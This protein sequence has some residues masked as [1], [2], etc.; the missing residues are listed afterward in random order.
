MNYCSPKILSPTFNKPHKSAELPAMI[1]LI[2][3][4][5]TNAS[6]DTL[7]YQ[8]SATINKYVVVVENPFR[9]KSFMSHSNNLFFLHS[10]THKHNSFMFFNK[11]PVSPPLGAIKAICMY[12]HIMFVDLLLIK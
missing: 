11:F 2:K 12:P 9:L 3:I 4:P 7:T 6:P 10:K 5:D 8:I 1:F